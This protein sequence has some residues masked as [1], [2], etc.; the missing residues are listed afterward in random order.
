MK[1]IILVVMLFSYD[2]IGGYLDTTRN[3][4][5]QESL[6]ECQLAQKAIMQDYYDHTRTDQTGIM[7][8]CREA[9]SDD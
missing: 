6:I 7:T 9:V 1:I 3:E 4:I 2:D 8:M 5:V